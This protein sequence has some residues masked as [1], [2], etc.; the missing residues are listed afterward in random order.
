M[1]FMGKEGNRM[2][3]KT[4]LSNGGYR[5]IVFEHC[6]REMFERG[7]R[8]TIIDTCYGSDGIN[9]AKIFYIG[10]EGTYKNIPLS[11]LLDD[12]VVGKI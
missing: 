2:S 8:Y 3:L 1:V 9:I 6:S 12:R 5:E 7:R 10:D 4:C 11:Y